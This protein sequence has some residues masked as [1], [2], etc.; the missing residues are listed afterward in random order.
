MLCG[1]LNNKGKTTLQMA[2]IKGSR[3]IVE[4]RVTSVSHKSRN[5]KI[6]IDDYFEI[7][8]CSCE[9]SNA[10]VSKSGLLRV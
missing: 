7:G 3:Y 9:T 1:V 10:A 6:C 2:D 4:L 8:S 5:G